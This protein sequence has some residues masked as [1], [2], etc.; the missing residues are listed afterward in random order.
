MAV[1]RQTLIGIIVLCVALYAWVVY[2]PQARDFLDRLG[3]LSAL[4]IELQQPVAQDAD[5][6]QQPVV[7]VPVIVAAVDSLALTDRVTAIGDGRANRSVT[8]R[9]ETVGRITLI[10]PES[11]SRVEAGELLVRLDDEAETIA[12]EKARILLEN[13]QDEERRVARLGTSGAVTEVRLRETELALRTA[14]LALRQAEF[15][16]AQ[17]SVVAP[18]SG[19]V[20]IIDNEVGDRVS[21]QE[22]LFIITDRSQILIDFRV[23]ERVIGKMSVGMPISITPLG[24]RDVVLDGEISAID[25]IVD[26]ASRTLR[27]QGRV[28]N[29][30]DR[31]RVGM[32]FSVALSF[33][34][35]TL[36]AIDPLALQWS[37]DGSFV[38]RVQDGRVQPVPVRIRNRDSDIVLVEGDLDPGDFVVTEGVQNL[39]PGSAVIVADDA[40]AQ[41]V[42]LPSAK[43]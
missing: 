20:G 8:V 37:G 32:A 13:A 35:E 22:A 4:G 25:T 18:I 27:V 24:L 42:Q 2:V 38:W 7:Q 1:L 36:L 33:P 5:S 40:A 3:F 21:A 6:R 11:G 30:E 31:L 14:E 15:D 16:L 17:R 12:L 10:A 23:P 19:W 28:D 43:L 34:G 41:Q 9:S 29:D 26:R 39:R